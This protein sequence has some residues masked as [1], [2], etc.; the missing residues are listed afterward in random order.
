M[1]DIDRSKH[2]ICYSCKKELEFT[3]GETILRHEECLYC[4]KHLKCCMMCLHY[5]HN[6]YNEC[7]ET[8]AERIVDKVKNNFCGYFILSGND[9]SNQPTKDD[10]E[11][12]ASS[13]FKD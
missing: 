8:N 4:M 11:N 2:V 10:L 13:L 3:Q 1:S 6:V 7:R 5:D 9:R 12:A